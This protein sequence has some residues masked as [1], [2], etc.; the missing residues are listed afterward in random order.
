MSLE[1]KDVRFKLDPDDH[2]A[3]KAICDIVGVDV[4]EFIESIVVPEIRRRTHEA[5]SLAEALARRGITGK[6][7][8]Q[9]GMPGSGQAPLPR[10]GRL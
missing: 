5:I 3:L 8:E 6:S 7:R 1:R 10:R 2:A 9:T 4:G